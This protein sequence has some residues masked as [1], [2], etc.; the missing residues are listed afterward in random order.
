[1]K[2]IR[3]CSPETRGFSKFWWIKKSGVKEDL[4][5]SMKKW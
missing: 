1:M 4:Y 3:E 2:R 5:E